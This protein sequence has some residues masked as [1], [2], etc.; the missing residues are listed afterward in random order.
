MISEF[1]IQKRL[2]HKL[3]A[4]TFS[5]MMNNCFLHRWFECDFLRVT[6]D[7]YSHEFEIKISKQDFLADFK[8]KIDYSWVDGQYTKINKTKHQLLAEGYKKAPNRFYFVMPEEIYNQVKTEI[9]S[10]AGIYIYTS[11]MWQL[12]VIRDAKVIH[13]RKLSDDEVLSIAK[14]GMYRHLDSKYLTN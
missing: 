12:K 14:K 6:K 3:K 2:Y 7:K 9:P 8:K 1:E 13:N 5:V 10:Y 11:E 4:K